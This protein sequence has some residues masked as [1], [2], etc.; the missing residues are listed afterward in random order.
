MNETLQI[1]HSLRVSSEQNH[2]SWRSANHF[3]VPGAEN[4]VADILPQ[5]RLEEAIA[6]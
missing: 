6:S 2:E 1:Y 3:S 5:L 4:I